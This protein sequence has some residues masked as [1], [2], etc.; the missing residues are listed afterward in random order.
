MQKRISTQRPCDARGDGYGD[1]LQ[2]SDESA[3]AAARG[4]APAVCALYAGR[5]R[6]RRRLCRRLVW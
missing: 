4:A 2:R 3:R 6:S 1:R 5:V